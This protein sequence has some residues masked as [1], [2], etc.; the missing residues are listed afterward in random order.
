MAAIWEEKSVYGAGCFG[1]YGRV[2]PV[3]D[4]CKVEHGYCT[5]FAR[6]KNN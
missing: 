4:L 2:Q 5:R 6:I 3:L 1:V